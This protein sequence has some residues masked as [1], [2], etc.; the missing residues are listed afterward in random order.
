[1]SD[2]SI[3]H[4][5]GQ[6]LA[7]SNSPSK[8]LISYV[9]FA[10]GDIPIYWGP[11]QDTFLGY[12]PVP[13]KNWK[14]KTSLK[15]PK[16][17]RF[18][19]YG[20]AINPAKYKE[21]GG[22]GGGPTV[23]SYCKQTDKRKLYSSGTTCQVYYTYWALMVHQSNGTDRRCFQDSGFNYDMAFTCQTA[24]DASDDDCG[25]RPECNGIGFPSGAWPTTDVCRCQG[26]PNQGVCKSCP[27]C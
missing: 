3:N 26:L 20:H 12:E 2:L 21:A 4:D 19:F 5:K 18:I 22:G 8:L 17:G 13:I 15:I 25:C 9:S 27:S 14:L 1:M 16:I 6:P 11:K 24:G 23:Y 7:P 10:T